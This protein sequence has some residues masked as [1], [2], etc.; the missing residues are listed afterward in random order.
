MYPLLLRIDHN[1]FAKRFHN[2]GWTNY[3]LHE[4]CVSS[5]FDYSKDFIMELTLDGN[6]MHVV[7]DGKHF[8]DYKM[9][10]PVDSITYL[11]ISG[12]IQAHKAEIIGKK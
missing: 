2:G 4:Q 3:P 11:S 8:C 1:V 10:L 6:I 5:P 12:S 9:Y 7:I